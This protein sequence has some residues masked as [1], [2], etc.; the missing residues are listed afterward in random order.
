MT[1]RPHC[2]ISHFLVP[3]QLPDAPCY[4][5]TGHKP[6]HCMFR[7]LSPVSLHTNLVLIFVYHLYL[8]PLYLPCKKRKF[9][10]PEFRLSLFYLIISP[11][12]TSYLHPTSYFQL[13]SHS[14]TVLHLYF[15]PSH[16]PCYHTRRASITPLSHPQSLIGFMLRSP[17]PS[18]LA[19]S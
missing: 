10:P 9:F 3:F 18:I 15:A 13:T 14:L 17:T 7:A 19:T 11:W 2:F 4:R 1:Y 16:T 12:P 5:P 8:T 6:L